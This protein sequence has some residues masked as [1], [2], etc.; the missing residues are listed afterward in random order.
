MGRPWVIPP[1]GSPAAVTDTLGAR[2]VVRE[3]DGA[4]AEGIGVWLLSSYEGR[5]GLAETYR[6]PAQ[7]R[8]TDTSGT[9]TFDP[10]QGGAWILALEPLQRRAPSSEA[11]APLS[12]Q[13]D[14]S[15]ETHVVAGAEV[16]IE[17]GR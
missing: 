14:P 9:A 12:I 1:S 2:C 8:R 16:V 5:P 6:T 13:V 10:V 17:V 11:Y 3:A 4:L 7:S 15:D